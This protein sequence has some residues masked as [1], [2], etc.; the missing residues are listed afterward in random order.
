M[1][2]GTKCHDGWLAI[3]I[4]VGIL[5]IDQIVKIMVK[6]NM[7]LRESIFITDWFQINFIEN[8][9]MAYGMTFFK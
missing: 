2:R 6:T 5:V 4:V 8:N 9:G 1:Q 3:I 7:S